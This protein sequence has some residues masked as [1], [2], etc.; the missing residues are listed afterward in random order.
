[1]SDPTTDSQVHSH[2]NSAEKAACPKCQPTPEYSSATHQFFV[3][4]FSWVR[5]VSKD[6]GTLKEQS[7]E[8][9][10]LLEIAKQLEDIRSWGVAQRVP[11][12]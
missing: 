7:V 1:M 5:A 3:D 11:R 10:L 2:A 12:G 9:L 6:G 4:N 8:A